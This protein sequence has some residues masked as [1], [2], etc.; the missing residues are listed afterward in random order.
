MSV[1][2][3]ALCIHIACT[4]CV[5]Y[6]QLIHLAEIYYTLTKIHVGRI[7]Y[8]DVSISLIYRMYIIIAFV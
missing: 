5:T 3:K 6:E 4:E 7:T 8:F 2:E 1:V